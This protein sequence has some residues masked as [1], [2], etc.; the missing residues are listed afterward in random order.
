MD[1]HLVFCFYGHIAGQF[2]DTQVLNPQL[3]Q[4]A[5]PPLIIGAV[6]NTSQTNDA[7]HTTHGDSVTMR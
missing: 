7:F 2:T 5:A 1:G 6:D 3:L 4:C